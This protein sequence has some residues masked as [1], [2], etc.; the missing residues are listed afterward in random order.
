MHCMVC[1]GR[2]IAC[3]K[4]IVYNSHCCIVRI[5]DSLIVQFV[6]QT[7]MI[8]APH[9]VENT[10]SKTIAF[11]LYVCTYKYRMFNRQTLRFWIPPFDAK[12]FT[13]P[14]AIANAAPPQ[15]LPPTAIPPRSFKLKEKYWNVINQH[16]RSVYMVDCC[17][18][19][20]WRGR[21]WQANKWLAMRGEI[22]K[23]P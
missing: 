3:V 20:W 6:Q 4:G 16:D 18:D 13:A 9:G 8:Y 5:V 15:E 7:S 22:V 14:T 23:L 21:G 10:I 12:E 11:T 2:A 19:R 17:V 1:I